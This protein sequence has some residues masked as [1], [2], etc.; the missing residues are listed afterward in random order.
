M[1]TSA[2]STVSDASDQ[3]G[4]LPRGINHIGITVPDLD[5]ATLFFEQALG[6]KWCY[7][8][9]TLNDQPRQGRIVELQLGLPQGASIY[10]LSP[11]GMLIE[12]QTIPHGYYYDEKS[13]ATVWIPIRC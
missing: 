2:Y 6:T 4:E 9:L 11:W 12:L 5:Q 7:D 8:G 3:I 10:A 13:E 1:K